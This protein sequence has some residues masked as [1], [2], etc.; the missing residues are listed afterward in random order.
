MFF[1]GVEF[2]A[3]SD[4]VKVEWDSYVGL[5]SAFN[6]HLFAFLELKEAN[7][8]VLLLGHEKE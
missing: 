5:V 7:C 2:S 6:P 4:A 8:L 3:S 1:E